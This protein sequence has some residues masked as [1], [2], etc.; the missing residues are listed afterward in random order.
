[1]GVSSFVVESDPNPK[2]LHSCDHHHNKAYYMRL[3]LFM[4]WISDK[5]GADG[6]CLYKKKIVEDYEIQ[7]MV[8]DQKGF[9]PN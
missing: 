1:M 7:S 4:D 2:F 6:M 8:R 3:N 5:A 9:R